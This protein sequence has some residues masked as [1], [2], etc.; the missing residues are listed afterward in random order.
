MEENKGQRDR[1]C[2]TGLLVF[3]VI[4]GVIREDFSLDVSFEPRQ[5]KSEGVSHDSI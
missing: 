2:Q 3:T 4:C 5:E 1:K